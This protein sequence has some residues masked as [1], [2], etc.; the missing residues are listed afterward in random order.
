MGRHR[1]VLLAA[2]VVLLGAMVAPAGA[3]APAE[4]GARG[5]SARHAAAVDYWTAERVAHAVP[6][7][8]VVD[9]AAGGRLA[10]VP[11]NG[12]GNGNGGG[13][14]DE[15]VN[16]NK[17]ANRELPECTGGGDPGDGGDPG[18]GGDP[19]D[20]PSTTGG[21]DWTTSGYDTAGSDARVVTGKVLFTL[22]DTDYVCS[23]SAVDDGAIDE[24]AVVLTAGHC[25][26]EGDGITWAT[27]W[28]FLP[29][30]AADADGNVRTCDD[31]PH[32]CWVAS[33]LVTTGDWAQLGHLDYDVGFAVVQ[34]G[35]HD[36]DRALEAML[37]D[38]GAAP[39]AIGFNR[40]RGEF[41]TA[42]GYPHATPYDGTDLTYCA[43]DAIPN[44]WFL[45]PFL[46]YS[47][48]QGLACDMTG[49]SSGGPWYAEF[50][51]GTG[52][53][54]AMSVN[55]YKV[56]G[57]PY[58]MYGTY[59]GYTAEDAWQAATAATGNTTVPRPPTIP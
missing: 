54:I 52:T 41:V 58:T 50:S 9:P 18:G 31:S 8:L 47:Y 11:G 4:A 28:T 42:F 43:G 20:P 56:Q 49:G 13:G 27:N 40:P 45:E 44:H 21:A 35:G 46:L 48:H 2:T 38:E 17:K 22:G 36:G 25:V 53:G 33:A 12:N 3:A 24:R 34:G 10:P 39:A 57:D 19:G 5:Q 15:G 37:A 29:E 16:C 51:T 26:H 32:G 30:F 6:R 59:F 1:P 23:G 14:G 7:V 55:S